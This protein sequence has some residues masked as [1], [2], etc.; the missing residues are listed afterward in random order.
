VFQ[1]L[2]KESDGAFQATKNTIDAARKIIR[3]PSSMEALASAQKALSSAEAQQEQIF[4]KSSL[5]S[6]DLKNARTMWRVSST[7]DDLHDK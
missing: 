1:Q 6:E 4:A 2:D 3:N 7:L 5:N